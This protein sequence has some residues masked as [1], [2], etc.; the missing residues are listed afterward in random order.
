MEHEVRI[1]DTGATFSCGEQESVL[2][3]MSRLGRKGI[4]VGCRGGGCGV[5][6]VQ[7]IHGDYQTRPMSRQHV[8]SVEESCGIALA[9]CLL[10][11]SDLTVR[12]VGRLR[13]AV[14]A[15]PYRGDFGAMTAP[16]LMLSSAS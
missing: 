9:C 6:K 8:S 3:G 4:P 15:P 2:T 5:C 7:V 1:D 13:K 12:I 14:G 11:R 10:P 16:S